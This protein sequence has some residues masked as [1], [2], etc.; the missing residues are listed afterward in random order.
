MR[1][2]EGGDRACAM[3]VSSHALELGRAEGTDFAV[4]VFT[5]LTQDHLDFHPD[6]EAYFL[7]KRR[8]FDRPGPGGGE[9]R[10]PLRPPPG[11]RAGRR[12]RPTAWRRGDYRARDVSFDVTGRRLH[13][14]IPPTARW[15]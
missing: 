8:L 1:M 5:N 4:K 6:M 11:G 2:L 12:R 9:R 10:R 15:R 7:A 3:E 14:A 13:G